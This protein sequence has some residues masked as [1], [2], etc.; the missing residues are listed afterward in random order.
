MR[1]NYLIDT[2]HGVIVD[3]EATRAIRKAEVGASRT[4]L[5]RTEKRFGL[6]PDYVAANRLEFRPVDITRFRDN[7][8]L[9]SSGLW[10][11]QALLLHDRLYGPTPSFSIKSPEEQAIS[12][13]EQ[14]ELTGSKRLTVLRIK[15]MDRV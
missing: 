2:D 15:E 6:R 12:R 9:R 7:G 8:R 11:P 13:H 1:T 4:M 5:E 3:V 10:F 14:T